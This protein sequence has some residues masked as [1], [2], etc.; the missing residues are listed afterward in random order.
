[1]K[2]LV[3]HGFT[4]SLDTVSLLTQT[5]EQEGCTVSMPVLRGHSTQAEHLFRVHWR[6]WVADAREALKELSPKRNE[7]VIVAGL[8]VGALVAS[9]IAAEFS[10]KV[11]RLAL[12]APAFDFRSRLTHLTPILRKAFNIWPNE[13]SYAGPGLQHNNTNYRHFPIESF[14]QVLALQEVAKDLLPNIVCPVGSFIAQKDPVVPTSV[15]K[16]IDKK[17][18][19]GP[20]RKYIYKKSHHELLQDLQAKTVASDIRDFLMEQ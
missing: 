3:L 20:S 11:S 7:K 10:H 12:L 4:G 17:I 16:T 5:L 8:S 19:S 15:L 13:T 1:M 2:A 18:G 9:L 14:Q 6:D